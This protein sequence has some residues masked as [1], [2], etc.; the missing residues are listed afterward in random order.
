MIDQ[1]VEFDPDAAAVLFGANDGQD[2]YHEGKV[3]KV[4]TRAWRKQYAKRVGK[5]MDILTR[6]A[7]STG[8]GTHHEERRLS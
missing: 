3:L 5:A 1:L 2:F 6:A 4:G 8:W 7:R